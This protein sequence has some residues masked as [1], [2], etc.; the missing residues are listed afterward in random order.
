M[1]QKRLATLMVAMVG[2]LGGVGVAL[3]VWLT[4]SAVAD[5]R[6]AAWLDQANSVGD[7]VVKAAG[8]EGMERGQTATAIGRPDRVT[9]AIRQRMAT[10]RETGD[11]AFQAARKLAVAIATRPDHPLQKSLA[12]LDARH[13]ELQTARAD[14]DRLL[15]GQP[16]TIDA[17]RWNQIITALIAQEMQVRR[18]ALRPADDVDQGLYDNLLYREI[19]FLASE[20]AGR[21]RALLAP[22]IAANRPIPPETAK[23]LALYR[24]VTEDA[25]QRLDLIV[26][27]TPPD[28]P[29]RQ[30]A[31]TV[32][33][34]YLERFQRVREAVYAA[35]DKG[36]P[37]PVTGQ[38]W[39][40]A[41]TAGINAIL[42]VAKLVSQQTEHVVRSV[43]TRQQRTLFGQGLIVTG[44]LGILVLALLVMRRRI[45]QPITQ[46]VQALDTIGQ[47]DLTCR[48]QVN[49]Q[50]EIGEMSNGFNQFLGRLN[51]TVGRTAQMATSVAATAQQLS[52]SAEEVT[53]LT[54]QVSDTMEQS[55]EGI[56]REAVAVS[57]AARRTQEMNDVAVTVADGARQAA[58][59]SREASAAAVAG[60][61]AVDQAIVQVHGLQETV[62][63]TAE[64]VRNL[65]DMSEQI[66]SIV[67]LIQGIASQ[68]NL[69]ALNAAIEAARAGDQGRGF[70]VVAE[71]VRKLAAESAR[72]AGQITA[73]IGETQRASQQSIQAM[74]G[75][76]AETAAC[77]T[78]IRQ[79]GDSLE[80]IVG[81]IQ[82]N[83]KEVD[84]ISLA[85]QQLATGLGEIAETM[86]SI[87]ALAEESAAGAEEV[88]ASTLEQRTAVVE[89]AAAAQGL[90]S[91][92][93]D[94]QK[95]VQYFRT[96]AEPRHR[97]VGA[98]A[99]ALQLSS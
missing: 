60:K 74:A 55:A 53:R 7:A 11:Q 12:D 99:R 1:G 89:V 25:L 78:T 64:T 2:G 70:A 93:D 39:Y 57:D 63:T 44:V 69:L 41:S 47:G 14:T 27:Q 51:D 15:S 42:D 81:L 83:D 26:K 49:H 80:R 18:D 29:L 90:A 8:L 96:E 59:A 86:D 31:A 66:G 38:Q 3:S 92:A 19:V 98:P 6:T 43:K 13:A 33:E 34:R 76:L 82:T 85:N 68:T 62:S 40:E 95:V 87:A 32:H 21:E 79:V 48:L 24:G 91:V 52:S 4:S 36:Q 35:S 84:A 73:M 46:L 54:N 9:P 5:Y 75:G 20:H 50:D 77:V 72:S 56:S 94:M 16:G 97:A 28:S 22:L 58:M 23:R 37:Y 71:E 65:G 45:L 17:A 10:L 30:A 67:Q 88:S 61:A